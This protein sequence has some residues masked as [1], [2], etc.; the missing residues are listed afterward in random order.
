MVTGA[1]YL[2]AFAALV[3][4]A[5]GH[6]TEQINQIDT[7]PPPTISE[8]FLV[9]T[10]EVDE[11]NSTIVEQTLAF[12]QD[13]RRSN[14]YAFGSLVK[15]ALQ[16]IRRCDIHP[17]GWWSSAGGPDVDPSTWQCSNM[18]IS[19]IGELP[20]NCEFNDFWGLPP[21]KYEGTEELNGIVGDMWTYWA[22]EEQYA[23]YTLVDQAVPLASGKIYS[24]SSSLWTIFFYGFQSG[25]PPLQAF[26]P[27]SGSDCPDATPPA[28]PGLPTRSIKVPAAGPVAP[29]ATYGDLMRAANA[30]AAYGSG[31]RR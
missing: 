24:P 23:F 8:N 29:V 27:L 4:G 12:D 21:M 1:L 19:L 10:N 30:R 2:A 18:T 20:R 9:Y 13:A 31:A 6:G 16:Q 22:A 5:H 17:S 25:P 15:G 14:M 26:E 28:D 7:K 3:V 11:G